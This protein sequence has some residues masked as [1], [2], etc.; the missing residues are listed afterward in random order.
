MSSW[1]ICDSRGKC[2]ALGRSGKGLTI[3]FLQDPDKEMS[4]F[5]ALTKI[6]MEDAQAQTKQFIA[7][8]KALETEK[9]R[10]LS[11]MGHVLEEQF[12]CLY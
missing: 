1:F 5:D 3:D 10:L 11:A 7:E 2:R 9:H 8:K 4:N 12:D 6:S